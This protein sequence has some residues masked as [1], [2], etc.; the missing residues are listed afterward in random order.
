[1]DS[2]VVL[3]IV[4]IALLAAEML[5]GTFYLLL[6][7]IG[8]ACG[9]VAG[10]LGASFDTQLLAAAVLGAAGPLIL[11]YWRAQKAAARAPDQPLDVG[12]IVQ[13]ETWNSDGSARVRHRGSHWDAE[14]EDAATSHS[15]TLYI[16]AMRGSTLILSDRKP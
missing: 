11:H 12:E 13:V 14:L 9:G 7:A 4:A 6:I 10:W 16:K 15:A 8:V 2:F 1:M 3:F 5:T